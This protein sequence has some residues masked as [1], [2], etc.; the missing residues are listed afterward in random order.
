VPLIPAFCEIIYVG[1][2]SPETGQVTVGTEDLTALFESNYCPTF[3]QLS[4][5]IRKGCDRHQIAPDSVSNILLNN[6]SD[7]ERRK[8]YAQYKQVIVVVPSGTSSD[9][10][11]TIEEAGVSALKFDTRSG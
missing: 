4:R 8:H 3:L 2:A 6:V 1:D 9:V 7:H 10:M 5:R 11:K